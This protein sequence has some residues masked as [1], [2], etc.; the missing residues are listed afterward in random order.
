MAELDDVKRRV[1][2]AALRGLTRAGED[3]LGRAQ[4]EAPVAEGTLR[5]SGELDV[6]VTPNGATATV[7]FNEVYAARQHEE[8]DWEHPKGGGAKYLEGPLREQ[9][10]R[11]ERAI[12]LEVERALR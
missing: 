12:A 4:R 5:A 7:S 10:A 9:Q 3:L 11:Y 1:Q 8:L 6:D 2:A